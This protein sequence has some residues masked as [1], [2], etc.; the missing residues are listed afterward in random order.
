VLEIKEGMGV[1]EL[2]NKEN[3]FL[4]EF[5]SWLLPIMLIVGFLFIMGFFKRAESLTPEE[6]EKIVWHTRNIEQNHVLLG[7]EK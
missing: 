6:R 3:G 4:K 1:G 5:I 2:I 7:I